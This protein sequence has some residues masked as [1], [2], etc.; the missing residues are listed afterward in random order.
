MRALWAVLVGVVMSLVVVTG[1]AAAAPGQSSWDG[2]AF[3]Q[4]DP[5]TGEN[6]DQTFTVHFVNT[7]SVSHFNFHSIGIG[8][9]TGAT[10]TGVRAGTEVDH[11]LSG[12][13]IAVDN[14]FNV[15]LVGHGSLSNS[16]LQ[17]RIH[18]IFDALG[19][20]LSGTINFDSGCRG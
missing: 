15:Y 4:W 6:V 1:V 9:T 7:D 5:C 12:G 3:T 11:F 16:Y 20:L 10:Y 8:E 13:T 18:A 14:T 17:G 19:N 2:G